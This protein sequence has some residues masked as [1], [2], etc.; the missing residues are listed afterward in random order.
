MAQR[1]APVAHGRFG[2]RPLQAPEELPVQEDRVLRLFGQGNVLDTKGVD[3]GVSDDDRDGPAVDHPEELTDIPAPGRQTVLRFD[4]QPR[5]IPL[6]LEADPQEVHRGLHD[7]RADE[8]ARVGVKRPAPELKLKSKR[9]GGDVE[10]LAGQLV[11]QTQAVRTVRLKRENLVLQQRQPAGPRRKP[12]GLG[13]AVR[14]PGEKD[15]QYDDQRADAHRTSLVQALASD[16]IS[17]NFL[18]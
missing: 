7:R 8:I 2:D 3:G 10:G 4:G 13:P 9:G 15:G 11:R 18:P 12:G 17:I 16:S 1:E 6:P 14:C 5:E